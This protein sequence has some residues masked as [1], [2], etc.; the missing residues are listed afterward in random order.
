MLPTVSIILSTRNRCATTLETLS[1]IEACGLDDH[2]YELI[3]VDN[4]SRD[5][6]PDAI[7]REF[8]R[9]CLIRLDR[10]EGSVA[11]N[12]GLLRAAG[13][14]VAFFDD[15]SFPLPGSVERMVRHFQLNP[16]LAAAGFTVT[17]PNGRRE[18]SAY[19]N[20]FIG[21][22]VGLRRSA[23]I[24]VGPLPHDFF[25]QAEEYDLSLRLLDAGWQVQTFD[26]LHVHHAKSPAT[27]SSA[28]KMRLDVRNNLLVVMRRFPG[29]WR[30]AYLRDWMTRY[31]AMAAQSHRRTAAALG[32]AGGLARHTVTMID[33]PVSDA[34]F[35]QFSR[36][37]QTQTLLQSTARHRGLR[38]VVL[39]DWGKNLLAYR[40]ACENAG[41]QVVAIADESL[42]G[43]RYGDWPVITDA[44]A[45]TLNVDGAI[46]ANLSPV[47]AATRLAHW[48]QAAPFA[49]VD[50]FEQEREA[51][52]AAVA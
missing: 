44:Q 18:C 7:A 43:Q 20:V 32:F 4:A 6:T 52:V 35:E 23:L 2:A 15:D 34:A 42:A 27:R 12:H 3:V 9:A 22:G 1:R 46:I 21:C 16:R 25:M 39:V 28:Q 51:A 17:L 31:W 24:E 19:P 30:D 38:R 40:L 33:Q 37:N 8:R 29:D 5:G 14:Y 11:K 48:R 41:V 45:M 13:K 26:D 10:N 50:L 49:V 36:I 47:H